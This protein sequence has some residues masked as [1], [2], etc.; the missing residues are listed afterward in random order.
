M[1]VIL[2]LL[3][4]VVVQN[5]GRAKKM[6]RSKMPQPGADRGSIYGTFD[7][8]VDGSKSGNDLL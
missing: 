6:S 8:S 7:D 4:I 5:K 1:Q 3:Y 2:G